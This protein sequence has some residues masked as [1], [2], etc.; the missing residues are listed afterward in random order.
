MMFITKSWVHSRKFKILSSSEF[1]Y[2]FY[3]AR[4]H[5]VQF[6]IHF[7]MEHVVTFIVT[8]IF[9]AHNMIKVKVTELRSV[10]GQ[11]LLK[12]ENLSSF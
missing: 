12:I 9:I 8:S 3:V 4:M 1:Y 6:S 10:F 11:P 5:F 2:L 7:Y